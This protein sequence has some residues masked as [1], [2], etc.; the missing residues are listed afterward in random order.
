MHI[1]HFTEMPYP[2]V[3]ENYE[4]DYGSIRIVLPN[5]LLNPQQASDLYARYLEEYEYCDEIGINIMLNEHHQTATCIN[6]NISIPAAALARSTKKVKI[7]LLGYPLPNRNPVHVAEDIAMLDSISGGRLIAGFVRGVGTEMHP[8]NS[9]PV[10]NRQ[11]FYEAHDIVKKALTSTEPFHFEGQFN[12]F[13]YVNIWPR[14]IQQPHPPFWTTGGS[15]EEHIKWAAENQYTFAAFL[16]PYHVTER[17]FN[18]YRKYSTEA[19]HS[20]SNMMD[21][22]ALLSLCNVA[23]TDEEARQNAKE[24]MWYLQGYVPNHFWTP[25]GYVPAHEI[26]NSYRPKNSGSFTSFRTI[27]LEQLEE[28]GVMIAGSPDTVI[29]KIKYL[30]DRV[31]GLGHLLLMNQAGFLN[32]AKTKRS[33]E[34]LAKEVYPAIKELSLNQVDSSN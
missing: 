11:M 28:M 2:H 18:N 19:G 25:Y 26:L 33:L 4:N 22:L 13:R 15:N 32:S 14:A 31:G 1:Y 34:L 17:I 7:L 20:D 6:A 16:T 30:Y 23:D 21:K 12:H 27:T 24:I 10:Y 5:G 3:P 9:N 8:A 29:K